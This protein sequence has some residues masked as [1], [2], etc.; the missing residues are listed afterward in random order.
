MPMSSHAHDI[1]RRNENTARRDVIMP[2]MAAG[3]YAQKNR[4][5]VMVEVDVDVVS[6]SSWPALA[7]FRY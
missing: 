7:K 2:E 1:S 5:L 3:I 6:S 4:L